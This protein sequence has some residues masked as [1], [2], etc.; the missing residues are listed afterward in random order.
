MTP[1]ITWPTDHSS[2]THTD[3]DKDKEK[4][5][6]VHNCQLIKP[7]VLW[8]LMTPTPTWPTDHSSHTHTDKDKDKD[9]D[10]VDHFQ[11][12]KA[13]ILWKLRTPTFTWPTDKVDKDMAD[14]VDCW[15]SFEVKLVNARTSPVLYVDL[16]IKLYWL[17]KRDFVSDEKRET[18]LLYQSTVH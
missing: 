8:K 18:V 7:Y 3:R 13:Y 2:H 12:I 11:P 14:K 17:T 10:E 1:T 16:E 6:E 5:D 4:V 9:K 15:T